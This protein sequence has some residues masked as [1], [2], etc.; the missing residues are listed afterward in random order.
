[1][2]K[3]NGITKSF[4]DN[5]VLKNISFDLI[6]GI[7]ALLG[8]NGA[9]KTTLLRILCGFIEPDSGNVSINE[10]SILDNRIS[11]LSSIG[12]VQEISALYD[13]LNVYEF[14]CLCANLRI[15]SPNEVLGEIKKCVNTFA[16]QNVIWQKC[17]TLSK[18]YK[19][20]IE[21]A[22]AFL[23][24]PEILLLDEPTEGLDPHQKQNIRKIIKDYAAEHIVLISTHMLEDVEILADSI[25]LLHNAEILHHCSIKDFKL[26]DNSNLLSYFIKNTKNRGEYAEI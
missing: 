10:N 3:V 14:L 4:G 21:L 2:M 7:T 13:Y 19:K 1:M 23:G 26:I 12:Y 9:G 5:V 11:Y 24:E 15:N 17:N 16:L 22:A 6:K 8:E 18:G 25:L 20:R